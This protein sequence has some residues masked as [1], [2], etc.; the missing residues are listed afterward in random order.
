MPKIKH[1]HAYA[2]RPSPTYRSWKHMID[3]C[4]NEK[5]NGFE[6]YGGKGVKVCDR[7]HVFVNFLADMGER[8][9]GMTLDRL[10]SER[11][12]EPGNCKWS[13]SKE[14]N[15]HRRRIAMFNGVPMSR[16][17]IAACLGITHHCLN[18]RMSSGSIVLEDI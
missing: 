11:D 9:P 4:H 1:G 7:W 5:F 14:Q 18:K 6:Y 12:Y 15:R 10:D 17:E 13:T 8:P 16:K 2:G 3:R